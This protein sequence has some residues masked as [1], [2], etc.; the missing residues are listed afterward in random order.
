MEEGELVALVESVVVVDDG[1]REL[2]NG[3]V[4]VDGK[5]AETDAAHK[6]VGG[7]LGHADAGEAAASN[8]VWCEDGTA[9]KPYGLGDVDLDHINALRSM[10]SNCL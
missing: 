1:L 8:L 7:I 9:V 6:D 2:A 4:G 5:G 10:A 3:G